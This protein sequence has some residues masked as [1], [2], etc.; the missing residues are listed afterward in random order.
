MFVNI[1]E[2]DSGQPFEVFITLG[3]AGGSAMA[4]AEAMGRLIS[5]ALRSGI[6][7]MRSP[8]PAARH[9]V[10]SRGRARTEQGAVG[11]GRDRH[12]A[13]GVDAREAA[14]VQQEL[15]GARAV[16]AVCRSK[17]FSPSRLPCTGETGSS[18]SMDSTT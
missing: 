10:G 15:L 4:D 6:P 3:K 9:L 8:P 12:R 14:G 2:D 1:T 7:I 13:R 16:G 18:R 11:A 17:S 5:L